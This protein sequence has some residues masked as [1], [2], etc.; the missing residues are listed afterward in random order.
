[1]RNKVFTIFILHSNL[2]F[3]QIV[4]S[5]G[6]LKSNVD[7]FRRIDGGIGFKRGLMGGNYKKLLSIFGSNIV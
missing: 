1:M 6:I 4:M 3:V 7:F 5:S 2:R